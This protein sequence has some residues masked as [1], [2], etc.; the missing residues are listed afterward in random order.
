MAKMWITYPKNTN[1]NFFNLRL[2]LVNGEICTFKAANSFRE[3]GM[4]YL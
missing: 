4:L 3:N 2:I 1:L